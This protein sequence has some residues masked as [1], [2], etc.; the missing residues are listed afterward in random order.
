MCEF[1]ILRLVYR[2]NLSL[3]LSV[4]PFKKFVAVAVG[5]GVLAYHS[6]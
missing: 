6:V 1:L 4:E 5:A 3:L 2:S